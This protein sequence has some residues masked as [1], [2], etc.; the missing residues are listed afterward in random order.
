LRLS[1]E[2]GLQYQTVH[3]FVTADR[4]I[5]I[6]SAAKLAE[7]LGLELRPTKRRKDGQ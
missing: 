2:S 6:G 1:R 3:G 7:A 4:Q 5:S